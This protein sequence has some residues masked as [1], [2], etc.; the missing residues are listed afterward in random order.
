MLGDDIL[1]NS[2]QAIRN[3]YDITKC[4]KDNGKPMDD[5]EIKMLLERTVSDTSLIS[6]Y[7]RFEKGYA[8]ED[9]FMR[10]YS[11]LPWVKNVVPLGQEQFPEKSKENSQVPDY[12]IIFEAGNNIN[13]ASVLIEVKLV[14][15]DKQTYELQKYKYKVLEEY[16]SQKQE[17]LLFAIFWRKQGLWTVNSIESFSEKSSAY[18]ISYD[19]ACANDLSAIFGD[20]TYVFRKKFYRKS[21]FSRNEDIVTEFRHC[22]EK[23][24]RTLSEEISLDGEKYESLCVLE[25]AL[26]D[27]VF[28]LEEVSCFQLSN[29]ETELVEQFNGTKPCVYKLSTMILDYLRKIYCFNEQD[30]YYENNIIVENAFNIV[31][32]IR[33]KCGGEKFYLMPSYINE[34]ATHMIELQFGEVKRILKAYKET[35]RKEGC[36]IIVSHE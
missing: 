13:T 15:G 27:C 28:D 9:L 6:A 30:M 25:P 24:G 1:A 17:S 7:H 2:I 10:I 33:Q 35:P 12:E 36:K 11:L 8:A 4:A 23:Y 21:K 5:E 3:V 31:D 16:S 19:N 29:L 14:D 20:Y 18:K 26:L 34:T 32:V 22:H